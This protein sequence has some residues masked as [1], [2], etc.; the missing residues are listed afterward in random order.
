MALKLWDNELG[1]TRVFATWDAAKTY[2]LSV[3]PDSSACNTLIS[4]QESDNANI[5]ER[6]IQWEVDGTRYS[7]YV[8]PLT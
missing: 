1:S 4:E 7:V 6:V 8:Y 5:R 2:A 3:H